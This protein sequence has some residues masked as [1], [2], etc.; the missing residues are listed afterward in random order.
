VL[1]RL[2]EDDAEILRCVLH[3]EFLCFEEALGEAVGG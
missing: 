1:E 2:F 3:L